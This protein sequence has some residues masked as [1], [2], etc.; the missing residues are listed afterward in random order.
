MVRVLRP[1]LLRMVP[2]T[3]GGAAV[4]SGPPLEFALTYESRW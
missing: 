4:D 1:V 2:Q 3:Q